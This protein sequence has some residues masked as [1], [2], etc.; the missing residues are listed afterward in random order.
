MTR[1]QKVQTHKID[2]Q[3]KKLALTTTPIAGQYQDSC[4]KYLLLMND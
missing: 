1:S 2:Q 4:I 3:C